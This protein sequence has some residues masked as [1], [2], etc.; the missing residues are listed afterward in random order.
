MAPAL[1]AATT[2]PTEDRNARAQ[3]VREIVLGFATRSPAGPIML[4]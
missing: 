1:G 2:Q 4:A 3:A